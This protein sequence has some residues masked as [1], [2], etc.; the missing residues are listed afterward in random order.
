MENFASI[1]VYARS[2]VSLNCFSRAFGLADQWNFPPGPSE[3][4]VAALASYRGSTLIQAGFN[5]VRGRRS[6]GSN[7]LALTGDL[8]DASHDRKCI[9]RHSPT[10][11]MCAVVYMY[12]TER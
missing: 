7:W 4:R 11:R 2:C 9:T 6:L 3:D 5:G 8:L 1:A 12:A 10:R